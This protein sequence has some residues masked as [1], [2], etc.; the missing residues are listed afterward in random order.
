MFSFSRHFLIFPAIFS[1]FPPFF[2]PRSKVGEL[3]II[4]QFGHMKNG[5]LDVSKLNC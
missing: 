2:Q 5:Q 3:R 4:F 1:F